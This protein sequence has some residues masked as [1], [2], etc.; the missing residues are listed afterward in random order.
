MKL[1]FQGPSQLNTETETHISGG[2]I[3]FYFYF[4]LCVTQSIYGDV[5]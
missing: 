3:Y 4:Y 5:M 1:V 2:E